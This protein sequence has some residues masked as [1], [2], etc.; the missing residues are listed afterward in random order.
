MFGTDPSPS[1]GTRPAAGTELEL[2]L[3]SVPD[4]I[5][6]LDLEGR[7]LF[8]SAATR[9]LYG[10]PPE[11][12]IGTGALD[13]LAP[14][15]RPEAERRLARIGE[16]E[17]NEERMTARMMRP[18]GTKVWADTIG[19]TV[20]DPASGQL[21]IAIVAR[22]AG[23][24]VEAQEALTQV[25][26]RF[27][28]L[29][30]WIPAVV[31][32]SVPGDDGPFR[33]V[34]PQIE[35]L[36]GYP[37]AEWLSDAGLWDRCLHP[38]DRERAMG[39]EMEQLEQAKGTDRTVADEYRLIHRDGRTIWCRDIGRVKNDRDGRPYWRGLLID[40]TAER[41]AQEAL[42]TA[43]E[44]HRGVVEGLPAC[45]YEAESRPLGQ[46]RFVSSQIER[47]LGYTPEEWTGDSTLWRASLHADDRERVELDEESRLEMAPGSE[48]VSEYRLRH[49]SGRVVWVRDRARITLG[50][51]GRQ[52]IEG[53]L[54]DITAERAAEA[55]AESIADVMR[56]TC[57]ECGATW[58]ADRIEPC[59]ECGGRNIEAVSMN[60]ALGDLAAARR[61]VEGLLDGIQRHLE[62]LDANLRSTSGLA[63]SEPRF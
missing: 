35:D 44:R 41:T 16:A 8:A 22:E 36:T 28:T 34:S 58:A 19:R 43:H 51:E 11:D 56:L 7:F 63:D 29:V 31:Y 52:M 42:A 61:Q 13:L 17:G 3:D 2:L 4:V 20:R 6:C 26:E 14:D 15:D 21:V 60:A 9:A 46:W 47:L 49:R 55:G 23:E 37:A 12:L 1:A 40:I 33:Y 24:R 53:I 48:F 39:T 27:R 38:E 54:T 50:P 25:E 62:A 30:E 18:D 5:A 57:G 45:L 59:R 32:E 10:H